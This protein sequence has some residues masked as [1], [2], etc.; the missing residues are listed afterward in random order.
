MAL[1]EG[2]QPPDVTGNYDI[3]NLEGV[4]A[5]DS[6]REHQVSDGPFGVIYSYLK[7]CSCSCL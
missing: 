7:N 2:L 5:E 3:A 1:K 4:C 6:V